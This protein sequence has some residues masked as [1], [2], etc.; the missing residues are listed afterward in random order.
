MKVKAISQVPQPTD[1]NQLQ[2]F[3]GLCKYYQNFVKGFSSIAKPLT[4]LTQI[5][6]IWD[7]PY[8]EHA[9]QE[10]KAMFSLAPFFKQPIWDD[11]SNYILI[12]VL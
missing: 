11:Y 1:V 5:E 2:D 12:G 4:W 10:L 8:K 3:I 7:E 6:F 9:F